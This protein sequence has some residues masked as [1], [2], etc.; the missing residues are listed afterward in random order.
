M[1][2][3]SQWDASIL[4]NQRKMI[5]SNKSVLRYSTCSHFILGS[6]EYRIKSPCYKLVYFDSTIGLASPWTLKRKTSQNGCG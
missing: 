4:N 2:S 3:D 5:L 1:I 6:I